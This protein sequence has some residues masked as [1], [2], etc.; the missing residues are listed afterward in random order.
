M[1]MRK[2]LIVLAWLLFSVSGFA[3]AAEGAEGAGW[4]KYVEFRDTIRPDT[5]PAVLAE[6]KKIAVKPWK[7]SEKDKLARDIA[8]LFAR[9]PGLFRLGAAQGPIPLYR[10]EGLGGSSFGGHGA[11]WFNDVFAANTR[12]YLG[13][14]SSLYTLTHEL[15][16]VADAEHKIVRSAAFR[17]LAEPRIAALKAAM[18]EAGLA[19]LASAMASK[20]HDIAYKLGMPSFYAA[21]TI[22]EALAEYVAVSIHHPAFQPPSDMADFLQS[23]VLDAVATSDA[24][25]ALYRSGKAARLKGK[26]EEALALLTTAL[27]TDPEFTEALIERALVYMSQ[28]QLEKSIEDLDAAIEHMSD[29]DWQAWLPRFK[30]GTVLGQSGQ[31]DRALEDL[32]EAR[33]LA[34]QRADQFNRLI[35]QFET[36]R[37]MMK[38]R[39]GG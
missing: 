35:Q 34:P 25:V 7:A 2:Y 20:R 26:K 15:T 39:G 16:H 27:E 8:L 6:Q 32:A 36:F 3:A 12:N 28:G 31:F 1:S 5:V 38:G 30:R 22:Q 14:A 23:R 21:A 11:M 10:I 17:S 29:Y 9:A 33:R 37:T 24:S 18:H 13:V 4:Q 19:D